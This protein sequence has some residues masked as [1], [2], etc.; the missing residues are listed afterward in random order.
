MKQFISHFLLRVIT[1]VIGLVVLG[2]IFFKLP[3]LYFSGVIFFVN[4]WAAF[5]ELPKLVKPNRFFYWFLLVVYCAVPTWC[6][7]QLNQ[8]V[9]FRPLL[10][11]AFLLTCYHDVAAYLVGTFVG[12]HKLA[13]IISPKKT[14]EGVIG[15]FCGILGFI[16]FCASQSAQVLPL[17]FVALIISALSVSGDLFESWLKRAARVKD[18]GTILPG[19]GGMLDRIDSL[20]FVIPFVYFFR[21]SLLPLVQIIF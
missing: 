12:H 3:P 8:V 7:L 5:F 20:L 9:T 1:S 11:W 16:L 6:A 4:V 15:G 10:V 17:I 18:A 14:W 2:C 13:P 19:H 21:S